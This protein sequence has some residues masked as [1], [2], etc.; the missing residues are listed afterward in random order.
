[1]SE[2]WAKDEATQWL[3]RIDAVVSEACLD[4]T[5]DPHESPLVLEVG[6]FRGGWT[7]SLAVNSPLDVQFVGIDPYPGA[8]DVR[9]DMQARINA[10]GVGD[11]YRHFDSWTEFLELEPQLTSSASVALIHIDGEHTQSAVRTDLEMAASVLSNRGIIVLD[12]I[13]NPW[14]PGIPAA[15]FDF[16][17]K[18][19]FALLI[20]SRTKAYICR[21]A[22][23]A[24]LSSSLRKNLLSR[25][26]VVQDFI[27][28]ENTANLGYRE[29]QTVFGADVLLCVSQDNDLT[30]P[31]YPE[32]QVEPS[33]LASAFRSLAPP[34]VQDWLTRRI[35][36]RS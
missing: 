3:S 13:S 29:P 36:Q 6:V 28:Q 34:V 16:L 9:A 5:F 21:R 33:R 19:D 26:L 22:A 35:L 8:D 32:L 11:R 12:D 2:I 31:D 23:H 14:F 20:Y 17:A 15:T 18:Q 30:Y 27:W 4:E 10:L 7:G 25:Q 1:M 24:H